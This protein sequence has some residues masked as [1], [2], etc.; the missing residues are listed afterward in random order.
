MGGQGSGR[1]W[2][3]SDKT[4][5][6]DGLRLD[7]N[8]LVRDKLVKAEAYSFGTLTWTSTRTGQERGNI[9]YEFDTRNP[10]DMWLRVYYSH[11]RHSEK[12]D[13]L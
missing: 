1:Q 12:S 13:G 11:T 8:K 7:L 4:K 6:D 10:A 3:W 5:L 2:F 9:R